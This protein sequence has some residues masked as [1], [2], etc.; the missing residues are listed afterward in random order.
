MSFNF[1]SLFTISCT[2]LIFLHTTQIKSYSQTCSH[3]DWIDD[4]KH[5]WLYHREDCTLIWLNF[6]RET[7]R[8]KSSLHAEI[9]QGHIQAVLVPKEQ[10]HGWETL[11]NL[12]Q[13]S[14]YRLCMCI[15]SCIAL[16]NLVFLGLTCQ[17]SPLEFSTNKTESVKQYNHKLFI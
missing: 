12:I 9:P 5:T 16:M 7:M 3:A 15:I 4:L 14:M 2:L 17:F 1:I 11:S 8:K 13:K 6:Q 10:C